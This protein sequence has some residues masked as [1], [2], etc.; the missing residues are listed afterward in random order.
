MK[1]V[2][3]QNQDADPSGDIKSIGLRTPTTG[4]FGATS[5]LVS[6]VFFSEA[7]TPLTRAIVDSVSLA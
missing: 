4:F 7:R 1:T 5:R 3:K 2:L 6:I